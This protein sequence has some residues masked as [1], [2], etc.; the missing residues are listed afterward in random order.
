MPPPPPKGRPRGGSTTGSTTPPG[1]AV[2]AKESL[3]RGALTNVIMN[4]FYGVKMA[5][6]KSFFIFKK[7]NEGKEKI[8]CPFFPYTFSGSKI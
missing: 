6:M 5:S 8:Q 3:R 4:I 2:L 7:A 1:P